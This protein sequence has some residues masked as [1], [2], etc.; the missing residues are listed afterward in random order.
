MRQ[1]AETQTD[2][3]DLGGTALLIQGKQAPYDVMPLP[4]NTICPRGGGGG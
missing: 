3:E 1:Q 2:C 4:Y